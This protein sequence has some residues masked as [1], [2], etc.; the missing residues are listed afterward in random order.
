[1]GESILI[2]GHVKLCDDKVFNLKLIERDLISNPQN[3]CVGQ[4]HEVWYHSR[5]CLLKFDP[6]MVQK[7]HFKLVERNFKWFFAIYLCF[8]DI[9]NKTSYLI[10]ATGYI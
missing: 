9:N 1:M 4:K 7:T 6:R 10:T 3:V 5:V 2:C 8:V